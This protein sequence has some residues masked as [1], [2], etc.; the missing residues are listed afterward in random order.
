MVSMRCV[1]MCWLRVVLC[2]AAVGVALASWAAE[3]VGEGD[4]ARARWLEL[5]R[6][7]ARHDEL[8]FRKGAPVISD[9][10]YDMLKRELTVLDA[11]FADETPAENEKGPGVG[12]D[13]TGGFATARHRVPMGSLAKVH[14]DEELAAFHARAAAKLGREDVTYR[15]EPK[16]DG[17]AATLTYERGRLAR[18]VT[19]GDGTEGDDVT[20][21][22]RAL[23]R[24]LPERLRGDASAWPEVIEVRGEIFMREA[25]FAR[26]DAERLAEGEPG[27]ATPRNLAVGTL[28]S[29]EPDDIAGRRLELVCFGWGAWAG[30]GAAARPES[31]AAFRAAAEAWG[32][33]VAAGAR[34]AT[35]WPELLDAVAA[36]RDAGHAGGFP[37][38][39]VVVKLER[40]ADQHVLGEAPGAPR[41]AVARKFEPPRVGTRLLGVIWQVGR[42]G[43]LTP[44]AELEPVALAGST[45]TRASLHNADEIKRRDLRVGD[46]VWVE[47]AGEIIPA[48]VGVDVA[49]REAAAEPC[50]VPTECPACAR[51]LER[52]AGA[53]GPR[54]VNATCPARLGRRL[55]HY[56]SPA[57]LDVP[58]LGPVLLDALVAGGV[59]RSPADLHRL[60]EA[61]WQ[62]LPGVGAKRAGQLAAA[63][64]TARETANED[65]ARLLFAL[66]I[67]GVGRETARRLAGKFH[68]LAELSAASAEGLQGAGLG[69]AAARG[70]ATYLADPEVKAE[71]AEL[72]AAGVGE[73]WKEENATDRV[74]AFAGR[75]V[76]LT[77]TLTRWSR[78]EATSLLRAAGAEV[79]ATVTQSTTL[80]VAGVGAGAKLD[81]ARRRGVEVIDEAELAK[82]LGL[83]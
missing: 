60:T 54:C 34:V 62:S 2:A 6:E 44:V 64:A 8:Y 69:E 50:V 33:P 41:W 32:L 30:E 74:G 31:L 48:I 7:V 57:A 23:V 61:D 70:V 20:A 24:S 4:P 73:R 27:F 28:R 66:G 25:E 76:T 58:G 36:L 19:R 68:G 10:E 81:E 11:R 46:R 26:L 21:N 38:D 13:R 15:V 9:H 56:V 83:P 42:S 43:V 40:L 77:G 35:G 65:G 47:K 59:A 72:L 39:G 63:F 55:A 45:V 67:P 78:A 71:F 80:V 75:S 37:T 5:R 16:Y 22:A 51:A 49:V 53:T 52:D 79:G 82:R 3:P 29:R 18:V 12:D 1:V 14:S 17:L